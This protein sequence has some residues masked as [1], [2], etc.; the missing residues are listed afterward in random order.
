M[1]RKNRILTIILAFVLVCTTLLPPSGVRADK[2]N[3]L[4][5]Q[6]SGLQNNAKSLKD[7]LSQ[8]NDQLSQIKSDKTKA[9]QAKKLLDD[10]MAAIEEQISNI[11]DQIED[12]SNL[13]S[14]EEQKL[15]DAEAREKAQ[16]ELFCKRVRSMEES[17]TVSY[18]S[19]LFSA[20]DF[21]D[22]VDRALMISEVME[23]DNSV[24]D[25]L[26]ATRKEIAETKAGLEASLAQQEQAKA[27]QE[28][29]KK[30]LDAKL[31]EAA[32]L[33]KQ[34]QDEESDYKSARDELAAEEKK[35]EAEIVR[36]Q[37]AL[38]AEIASGQISF[39]PGTG[40]QWPTP[41]IYR[42][43]SKFGYRTHPVTGEPN[44]HGGVDIGAPKNTQIHAA[45]G[46]VVTIST[47]GSSYGNYVVIQHDN[48]YSSLYAHM[49]SRAVKEG[50]IITQGQV[51]GYVG[52]TGSSTGYHLHFEIRLSGVRQ[53]P[54][55]YYPSL[56][57][58]FVY[59]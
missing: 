21:S 51:I 22:L 28:A 48:G 14:Q 2:E 47:Y 16:Y 11:E 26:T 41:G 25:A 45:R 39:D 8:I 1:K 53:D 58:Q 56:K 57:N 17:G 42:I 43:T 23:Y 33:V 31:D 24:M 35:I 13:I 30:E 27:E 50:D 49:N 19:I 32:E 34:I 55:S 46:G 12:Y 29:A 38:E 9:L 36:K 59:S 52:T 6:I 4:R 18:W 7:R 37:K 5:D 3:D 10:Q 54:I 44:Y 15:D 40:W 20:E